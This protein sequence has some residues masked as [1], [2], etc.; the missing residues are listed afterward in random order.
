MSDLR[1]VGGTVVTLD[2]QHTL[3]KVG[4]VGLSGSRIDYVGPVRAD[5]PGEVLDARG[6]AV[7]PGLINAHTH[8]AMTLMRSY[9]DDMPLHAWLEIGRAHV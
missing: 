9:A 4:E 3:L 5:E 8:V 1:I 7:M 6:Q 2:E